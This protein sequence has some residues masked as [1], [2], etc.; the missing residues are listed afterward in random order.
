MAAKKNVDYQAQIL[1]EAIYTDDQSVCDKYGI[2]MRSLRRYR[3]SLAD[4]DAEL[5]ESVR[6]KKAAFDSEW[7]EKCAPALRAGMEFLT[8]ALQNAGDPQ[9]K[10]PN[11]IAAAAGA[12]KIV[13]EVQMTGKVLD[14]RIADQNRR[15]DAVPG[16]V[17]G[18]PLTSQLT[19]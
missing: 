9:K 11:F 4:G 15:S 19:Q 18:E 1:V 12:I 3:K 2:S 17:S 8:S 6:I 14:A 7:A 13:A 16:S 5:A 10:N